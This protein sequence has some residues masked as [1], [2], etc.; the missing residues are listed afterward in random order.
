MMGD[1]RDGDR[2]RDKK[3]WKDIDR[4]RDGGQRK[5]PEDRDRNPLAQNTSAYDRYKKNLEKLWQSGGKMITAAEAPASM[6]EPLRAV[7]K[8]PTED[9]QRERDARESLRKAA[10]PV[11]VRKAV[12][13]YLAARSSL[14]DDLELLSK[15]M[16]SPSEAHQL[17]ALRGLD[18]RPDLG[19]NASARLL[20]SRLETV[21]LTA[22]EDETRDLARSVRQKLG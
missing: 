16:T 6:P 3:S 11:E 13:G 17:A 5:S 14:P 21:V 15:A 8:R 9:Q 20:K 1:Y 4:A 19:T 18:Q 7:L 12:E 22:S 10:G 2:P